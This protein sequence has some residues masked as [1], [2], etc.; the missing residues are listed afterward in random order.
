VVPTAA[1]PSLHN[2]IMAAAWSDHRSPF[3]SASGKP[4]QRSSIAVVADILGF[5]QLMVAAAASGRSGAELERFRRALDDAYSFLDPTNPFDGDER[6]LW[7]LKMFTDNLVM[8]HPIETAGLDGETELGLALFA[9]AGYQCSMARHGYFLR[10][11]LSIGDLY[12]DRDVVWGSGLIRAH[13][14]DHTGAPPRLL[15]GPISTGKGDTTLLSHVFLHLGFYGAPAGA[16]H[17]RQLL[18]DLTDKCVFVDYLSFMFDPDE[19]GYPPD[20]VSLRR[21]KG[22]VEDNLRTYGSDDRIRPKYE[23]LAAYHNFCISEYED[24]DETLRVDTSR[25]HGRTAKFG[26]LGSIFKSREA[27]VKT[28]P[29]VERPTKR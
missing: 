16:P 26:R 2:I 14:F 29:W 22:L 20:E 7:D 25:Y 1:T 10:G 12:M 15:L 24:L 6:R 8:G 4:E 18:V 11:G 5:R 19:E 9:V 28:L 27:L 17:N 23:W 21:H 13:E 3:H